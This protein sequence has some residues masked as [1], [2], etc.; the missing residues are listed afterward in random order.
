MQTGNKS[1]LSR[2]FY[3]INMPSLF[4]AAQDEIIGMLFSF[5]G[6][7]WVLKSPFLSNNLVI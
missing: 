2:F 4:F 5:S 1:I 3:L 6:H 7:F